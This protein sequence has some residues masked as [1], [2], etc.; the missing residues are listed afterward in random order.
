MGWRHGH[1]DDWSDDEWQNALSPGARL[2]GYAALIAV[3][4]VGVYWLGVGF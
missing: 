4:A 2:L 3:S 1:P